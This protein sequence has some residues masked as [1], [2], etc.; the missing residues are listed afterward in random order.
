M[1]GD[2]RKEERARDA[3]WAETQTAQQARA[4]PRAIC[5]DQCD[6]SGCGARERR[7]HQSPPSSRR[8]RLSTV[9]IASHCRGLE[10]HHARPH[11]PPQTPAAQRGRKTNARNAL[12]DGAAR[13]RRLA[14]TASLRVRDGIDASASSRR[15]SVA[16]ARAVPRDTRVPAFASLPSRFTP[17][18]H[19]RALSPST[20]FA[21]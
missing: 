3:E 4:S 19:Q 18:H 9:R 15:L 11:R 21:A 7:T 12:G 2:V 10:R 20:R 17:A 5:S 14:R 6:A 13:C 16:A 1:T 8:S